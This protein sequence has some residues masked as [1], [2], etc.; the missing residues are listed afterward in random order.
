M[1]P[2]VH[3]S[4][5]R[6][7]SA[8]LPWSAR[9]RRARSIPVA[10]WQA[11]VF[12][13]VW[14][15][16]V[17]CGGRGAAVYADG[18]TSLVPAEAWQATIG[19]DGVYRTGSWTPLLVTPATATR[20]WVE[21]P[22]GELV[23]YPPVA[24][25]SATGQGGLEGARRFRVRFGR[26]AGRVLV[27]DGN[28]STVP[29]RVPVPLE[30]TDEVLLVIGDL[31]SAERAARLLQ[32]EDGSRIR[33]V[34]LADASGLG[35]ADL[36]LDGA[37]AIIVC[38]SV[39]TRTPPE[40]LAG[41]DAWVR[42]GGRL[43]FLA[44]MSAAPPSLA[45]GPAAGW[46]P[47]PAGRG[48]RVTRMVPLRRSAAIETYSKA[49]RPLDRNALG[50]LEIPVLDD[51]TSIDGTIAAWE[52]NAATDLPLVVRRAH[53]F[54]TVTW[55]GLDLDQ[56]AFRNWQG[57]DS[58]LVELLGGRS[59][60]TVRS[61]EVNRQSLDLGGQLRLAV[62]RFDGVVP[63]PF[64]VIAGLALLYI[65]C[66]YPAE[67]WLVSRGGRP[68]LAWLTLPAVVVLF[69]G[70]AWWTA[71]R[72][73]GEAWRARRADVVDVDLAGRIARGSSFFGAWSPANAVIDV[74]AAPTTG[75][76]DAGNRSAVVS[77]YGAGGR[78]IGGVDCPTAHPS[79][80][81]VPYT[82]AAGL[83]GLDGVPIAASSSRLF[84]AEW[85]APVAGPIVV[86]TLRKDAQGTL[87]GTLESRLP[88]ALHQCSLFH[89]G[90]TYD[91]GSLA[92][93]ARFDPES[94]K[95]P[96][97]L[98][99][100][101]TRSASVYDRTRTQAWRVDDTDIDRIL[102]IA[103]FHAAAGGTSYTSL[104]A[105]RLGRIDLSPLLPI[106]RA[107]LVGRGPAGTAWSC[108]AAAAGADAMPIGESATDAT[109][110]WRI[111]IPVEKLSGEKPS[112]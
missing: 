58:L 48:G 107:I 62:D 68:A 57:T 96:K 112:P 102:E 22:D 86:S 1:R 40:T 55:V 2:A 27:D 73:K 80:A 21:D 52:G 69:A 28:G 84:E 50:G 54:G 6:L 64:E 15:A 99:S 31:P 85:M 83:D 13:A 8:P 42:R 72:W 76:L 100:A 24:D 44:G 79:L 19:F 3:G 37:D 61:R 108:A 38:G 75:V 74:G 78:G 32:R 49:G 67:W 70:L 29:L 111:V 105:G 17:W 26:P 65:A 95:G 4:A 5:G 30:S 101:L 66:L 81:S 109:A 23:G 98:A 12:V 77:W 14:G 90:W 103:G 94:G 7:S 89:A 106:D 16:L 36:D 53:G 39:V 47:G 10:V 56:G 11:V 18:A 91:V 104:E 92:P 34:P 25:G 59:R 87:S 82:S 88:F 45:E 35:P 93:G 43:V 63:V 46:L 71:G 60:Q 110:M 51:A 41:V 9:G 33:V 97:T 20:V